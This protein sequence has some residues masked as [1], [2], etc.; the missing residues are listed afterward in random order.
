MEI[1]P[2]NYGPYRDTNISDPRYQIILQKESEQYYKNS[3]FNVYD[4]SIDNRPIIVQILNNY[5]DFIK[6]LAIVSHKM[7][8]TQD[9]LDTDTIFILTRTYMAGST[10]SDT[11]LEGYYMFTNMTTSVTS[12]FFGNR[13]INNNYS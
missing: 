11:I 3:I 6:H 7:F 8:I 2:P 5:V 12:I 1:D 13:T 4:F 10:L 9:T